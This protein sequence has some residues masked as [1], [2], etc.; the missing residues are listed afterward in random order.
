MRSRDHHQHR[1]FTD[2][3]IPDTVHECQT[4][5]GV[6]LLANLR[7]HRPKRRKHG[8]VIRLIRECLHP[9]STLRMVTGGAR[10]HHDGACR[11]DDRPVIGFGHTQDLGGQLQQG[12]TIIDELTTLHGLSVSEQR[13]TTW[14]RVLTNLPTMSSHQDDDSSGEIFF[15]PPA[16]PNERAWRHPSELQ[17]D[18]P[19]ASLG[20]RTIRAMTVTT[21]AISVTLSLLLA[22]VLLPTRPER[23]VERAIT[24]AQTS[25]VL[26]AE[27]SNPEAS[28][29]GYIEGTE[30]PVAAM[31]SSG[32]LL[33]AMI[34]TKPGESVMIRTIDDTVVNSIVTA[35]EVD[36]GVTWLHVVDESSGTYAPLGAGLNVPNKQIIAF[37]KGSRVWVQASPSRIHEAEVGIASDKGQKLIP[38]DPRSIPEDT[39]RG[40][41]FDEDRNLVGWCV[42]RDGVTWMVPLAVLEERLL[43]LEASEQ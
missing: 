35:H 23:P 40:P 27:Q 36:L 2:G 6:P 19:S 12:V 30:H 5:H 21:A 15:N 22:V 31:S 3:Y 37:K 42:R 11:R 9:V 39:N 32:Y 41:A 28:K 18:N 1:R 13:D 8:F 38:L 34:E 24:F 17:R 16:P 14:K 29:F 10:K 33:T 20:R 4:T 25:V 7:S 43:R 26:A